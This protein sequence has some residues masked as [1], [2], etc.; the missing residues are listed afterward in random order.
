MSK[1]E[2]WRTRKYWE[3]LDNGLLI[4]EFL[5]IPQRKD[6][7]IARR[8][9]DGVIVLG[10]EKAIQYGGSFD[11]E[12]RDIIAI[13]TKA[14]RLGMSLMGQAF[15]TREILKRFKPKSIRTVAIC[16]RGDIE[17]EKLCEQSDIEVVVIPESGKNR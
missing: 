11:L 6:K 17:M 9:I 15:F 10:V 16:G 12:G 14:T 3:S 4:E 2:S 13:Q 5:A 7:S 1:H 8:L